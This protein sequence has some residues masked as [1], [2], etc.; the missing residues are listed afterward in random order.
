MMA[1]SDLEI[2]EET[3]RIDIVIAAKPGT[4]L[5]KAGQ[6]RGPGFR[7]DDG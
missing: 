3:D 4:L 2:G 1:N 6:K 7:R 5:K